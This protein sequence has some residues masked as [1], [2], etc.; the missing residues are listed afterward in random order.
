MLK[1]QATQSNTLSRIVRSKSR[2][3]CPSESHASCDLGQ[4][5]IEPR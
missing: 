5:I 3:P 2:R 4:A 1:K